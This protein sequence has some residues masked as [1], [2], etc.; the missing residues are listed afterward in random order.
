MNLSLLPKLE[1]LSPRDVFMLLNATTYEQFV[2]TRAKLQAGIC[3]FCGENPLHHIVAENE[4]WRAWPNPYPQANHKH[5]F[6]IAVKRHIYHFKELTQSERYALSEVQFELVIKFEIEGGVF[7]MRF[8]EVQL[9]LASVLHLHTNLRI[10]DLRGPASIV[11]ARSYGETLKRIYV[12]GLFER[13]LRGTPLEAL[14][15]DDQKLVR[16]REQWLGHGPAVPILGHR[17]DVTLVKD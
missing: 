6:V 11:F 3:Q 9:S 2:D 4:H 7:G 13:I 8:G 1:G 16:E 10:P 14:D 17:N 15:F 12:L 5:H